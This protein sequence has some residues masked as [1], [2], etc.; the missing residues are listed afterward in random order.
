MNS[1]GI[2]ITVRPAH[3][4][5]WKFEETLQWVYMERKVAIH[6]EDPD[7]SIT[8][9]AG[10]GGDAPAEWEHR[11]RE[12]FLIQWEECLDSASPTGQLLLHLFPNLCWARAQKEVEA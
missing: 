6:V 11:D 2:I 10:R 3:F 5:R 4:P 8:T 7:G 1:P 12:G 9:F